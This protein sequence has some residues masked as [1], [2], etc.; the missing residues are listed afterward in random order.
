MTSLTVPSN[1]LPPPVNRRPDA[2]PEIVRTHRKPNSRPE[3]VADQTN[4]Q[5]VKER[6]ST[7]IDKSK[8]KGRERVNRKISS[9]KAVVT[10]A[11]IEEKRGPSK[12]KEPLPRTL[13]EDLLHE[14]IAALRW[15]SALNVSHL[16]IPFNFLS[17]VCAI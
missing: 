13:L 15:E 7:R 10:N 9:R 12:S 11:V 1:P 2:K 6:V 3:T 16:P 17:I 4:D 14:H 5:T 8:V